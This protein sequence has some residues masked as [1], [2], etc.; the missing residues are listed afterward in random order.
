M[1]VI[2]RTVAEQTSG[3]LEGPWTAGLAYTAQVEG[4]FLAVNT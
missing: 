1:T 2:S 4:A 3:L